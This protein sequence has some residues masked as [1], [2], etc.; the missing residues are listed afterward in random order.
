LRDAKSIEIIN[1]LLEK[2]AKVKV[3]D[4]VAMENAKKILQGVKYC[5]NPYEVA[6]GADG[7]IIITEWNEFKYLNLDKIKEVMKTPIIFDGRNIYDPNN[8][9]RLGFKYISIGRK[10]I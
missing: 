1:I 5:K 8:L 2:K 9:K 10:E 4:P 7:L 3:Y 6:E